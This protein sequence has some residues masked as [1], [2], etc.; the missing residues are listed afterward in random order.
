M[1]SKS[2]RSL[3][4]CQPLQ[5]AEP[6]ASNDELDVE[7]GGGKTS[8]AQLLYRDVSTITCITTS[9]RTKN[10]RVSVTFADQNDIFLFDIDPSEDATQYW[11]SALDNEQFLTDATHVQP[12]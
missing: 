1:P 2:I 4:S 11:Y 8:R 3:L 10:K 12:S 6:T 9:F 7:G 5:V